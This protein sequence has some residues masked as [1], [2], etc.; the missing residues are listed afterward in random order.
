[1]KFCV[2]I[3]QAADG[4]ALRMTSLFAN[5]AKRGIRFYAWAEEKQIPRAKPA[6]GMTVSLVLA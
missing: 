1:M 2:E 5:R 3:L 6:I 4:A